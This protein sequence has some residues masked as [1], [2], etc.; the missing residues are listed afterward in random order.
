[1]CAW[2]VAV[3]VNGSSEKLRVNRFSNYFCTVMRGKDV[4]SFYYAVVP[5]FVIGAQF[6][7]GGTNCDHQ[8]E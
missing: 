1:M 6:G 8:V 2:G 7:K 3:S 4:A 5:R